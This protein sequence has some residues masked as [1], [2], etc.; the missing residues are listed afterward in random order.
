MSHP[1]VVRWPP[2][3]RAMRRLL[4]CT[5]SGGGTVPFRDWADVLPPDTELVI[6][7]HAGR[8]DRFPEP[9]AQSWAALFT[10]AAAA[11]ATVLDKPFD[12]FGH[13]MGALV[14][15]ELTAHLE[16]VGSRTPDT[17]IVSASEAPSN[18]AAHLKVPP[19]AHDTDAELVEWITRSGKL[20]H[21]VHEEPELLDMAVELLRA[22]LCAADSYRYAP[23]PPLRTPVEL[24]HGADDP[25]VDD[26]VVARWQASTSGGFRTTRLPGG[27][28]YTERDWPRL[29]TAFASLR[30]E[31]GI[32]TSA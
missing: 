31:E 6:L 14:A 24:V 25:H 32:G 13:S 1:G 18:W 16:Q 10:D 30:T 7:C 22:D 23:R 9:P 17:L 4:C 28:F 20:P 15:F 21:A 26:G 5:F 27:H 2:R 29:P 12:L 19:T 8:E 11:V 3:P